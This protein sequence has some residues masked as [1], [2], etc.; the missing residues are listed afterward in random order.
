MNSHRRNTATTEKFSNPIL[1]AGL[2]VIAIVVGMLCNV[3]E[4][5]LIILFSHGIYDYS[6]EIFLLQK[7]FQ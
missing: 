4:S 7:R 3:T 1:V 5:S 6:L 2:F